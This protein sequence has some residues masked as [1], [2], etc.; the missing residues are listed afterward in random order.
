MLDVSVTMNGDRG[1]C[2]ELR[3]YIGQ[4]RQQRLLDGG[5]RQGLFACRAVFTNTGFLHDP[6]AQLP[7]GIR[8][9]TERAQRHEGLLDVFDARFNDAFLLRVV[10]RT[11]IDP[12]TVSVSEACV[13]TLDF[14][15]VRAGPD[16]RA[17]RVVDFLCPRPL[18]GHSP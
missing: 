3:R 16:D 4:R 18:C 12:E 14:G 6:F 1:P 7:V 2:G 8:R 11:G 13:G 5:A 15:I 10:R 17:L 9:I